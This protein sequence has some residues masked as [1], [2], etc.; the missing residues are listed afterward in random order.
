MSIYFDK[1]F[2][3]ENMMGPNVVTLLDE[4]LMASNI[5]FE[6]GMRVLDLG[7]GKGLTSLVLADRYDIQV[8][9]VDLW[10]AATE[11]YNRFRAF[12]MDQKIIPIHADALDM[13]FA[14]AYFDAV[15]SIDSY[16]YF[17]RDEH[18]LDE[19]LAPLVKKGGIIAIAV[20]G[21]KEEFQDAIPKEM[22][23]SWT[24]EDLTTIR[25][26]EWWRN[27]FRQSKETEIVSI[28]EMACFEEPW[29]DWL[30]CDN[31]YAISDR[32]SMNAGAGKYMNFVSAVLK[33]R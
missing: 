22:L 27:I 6:P 28:Q 5:S 8:F 26:Y 23:L 16:H 18:Y 25:S 12:S 32:A 17:G 14:D 4:L 11:N 24:A 33:R 21:L 13:P 2:L 15:V 3:N 9:A 29:E 1:D 20:P 31:A 10:T 19:K 30:A 7:C